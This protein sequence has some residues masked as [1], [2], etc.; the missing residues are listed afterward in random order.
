MDNKHP[1]KAAIIEFNPLLNQLDNNIDHLL[2][3]VTEAAKNGAKL[4]V[5]PEMATTGYHY[6]NR[7]S[8]LP[9]ADTIPGKTTKRFEEVAKFYDTH[10]IIGMAEVDE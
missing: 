6:E 10:I 7:Q 3:A 8:I 4:I 2:A 9:F 5:T 1:F